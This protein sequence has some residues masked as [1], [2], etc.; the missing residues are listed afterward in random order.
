MSKDYFKELPPELILLLSTSLSAA[1]LNASV[2]TCRR[3]HQILQ[4]ELKS[5]ITPQ[6]AYGDEGN[7]DTPL[8]LVTEAGN[9]S[10][11]HGAMIEE[12][13]PIE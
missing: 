1:S 11:A 8:H 5:R 13:H 6:L 7:R 3:L 2:L 12:L 4:P 9:T 10:K